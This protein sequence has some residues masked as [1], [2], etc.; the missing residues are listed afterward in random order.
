MVH[1]TIEQRPDHPLLDRL[2]QQW[3]LV[4]LRGIAA[5][6]FGALAMVAPGSALL[7][8]L[9]LFGAYSFCDGVI[10]LSVAFAGNDEEAPTWWLVSIGVVGMLAGIVI[11][12]WPD[13]TGA[14]LMTTIG[15]WAVLAGAVQIMGAFELRKEIESEWLLL[16]SG[17]A[18]LAFGLAVISFP[19][20]AAV[21][22]MWAI[23][24]FALTF[25]GLWIAFALRLRRISRGAG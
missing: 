9:L 8:L 19:H 14:I 17:I 2:A 4:L 10:A 21:G 20:T 16:A 15:L 3:W 22:L 18:S 11:F 23:A 5:L 7:A 13:L 1:Q 25:G 12:G 24:L 6:L